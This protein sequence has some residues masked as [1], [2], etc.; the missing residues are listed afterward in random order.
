MT[1]VNIEVTWSCTE[2]KMSRVKLIDFGAWQLQ[3][4]LFHPLCVKGTTSRSINVNVKSSQRYHS[5]TCGQRSFK[6]EGSKT[7]GIWT[8]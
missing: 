3:L 1:T 7:K 8:T 2:P 5:W 4:F 6:H